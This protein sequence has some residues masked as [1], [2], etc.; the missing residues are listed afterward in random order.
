[1][2]PSRLG[3][4]DALNVSSGGRRGY[5]MGHQLS[6]G[7]GGVSTDINPPRG[8]VRIGG[9]TYNWEPVNVT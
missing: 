5:Q 7:M 2:R 8:P 3:I 9:K 6:G 1:M 4:S